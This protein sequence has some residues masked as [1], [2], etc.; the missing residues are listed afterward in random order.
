MPTLVVIGVLAVVDA[1]L[2]VVGLNRFFRKA[3]S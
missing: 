2:I 3:V 1:A